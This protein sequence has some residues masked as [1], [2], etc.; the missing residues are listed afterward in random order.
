MHA[1]VI[2]INDAIDKSDSADTLAALQNPN[3]VLIHVNTNNKEQYQTTLQDAKKSKSDEAFN[4][5]SKRADHKH[6]RGYSSL[7]S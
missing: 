7:T 3:A 2:K 1:A 4:R 6:V 5:V